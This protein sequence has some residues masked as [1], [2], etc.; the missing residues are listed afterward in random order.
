MLSVV[1]GV[2]TVWLALALA[3]FT[4]Y[5][6]GFYVTTIAIAVYGVARLAGRRH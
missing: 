3:Y 2:L 4:I 1:L 5:P 6:V